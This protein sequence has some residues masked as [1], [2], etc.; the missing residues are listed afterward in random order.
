MIDSVCLLH[1]KP[2]SEHLCLFCCLCFKDLTI[3]ECHKLEDGSIE[4]V[5]NDCAEYEKVKMNDSI[6]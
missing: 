1:G 2:R 6:S 4:D 3:E 5:C